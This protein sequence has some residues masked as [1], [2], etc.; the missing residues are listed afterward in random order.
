MK[1]R[2]LFK[3]WQAIGLGQNF[4]GGNGSGYEPLWVKKP[5]CGGQGDNPEVEGPLRGLLPQAAEE[6]GVQAT[7]DV[8]D[9]CESK[10]LLMMTARIPNPSNHK[11]LLKRI[12][13]TL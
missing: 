10:A 8:P 12:I 3:E 9:V 1:R 2:E 5:K 7:V 13:M 11:N 4:L 6:G